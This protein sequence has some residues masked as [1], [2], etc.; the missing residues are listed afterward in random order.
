MKLSK[1]QIEKLERALSLAHAVQDAPELSRSWV[2]GVMRD[3][4]RQAS[5]ARTTM[6]VPRLVWRAAT[7]VVVV[8]MLIVGSVLAWNADM[9]KGSFGGLF[10]E[11]TLGA[12]LL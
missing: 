5:S 11:T 10:T 3:V 4:R 7:V 9:R 8:S 2:Y 1:E 6:E 12:G